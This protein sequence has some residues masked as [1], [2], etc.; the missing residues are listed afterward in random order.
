MKFEETCLFNELTDGQRHALETGSFRFIN[1]TAGS[2]KTKTL[3]ALVLKMLL[4][5]PALGLSR[6]CLFTYTRKAAGEI[7]SRL[8]AEVERILS[9]PKGATNASFK[10]RWEKI[11]EEIPESF[12]GTID[13]IIQKITNQLI[14]NGQLHD[15]SPGYR[16]I[17]V[18]SPSLKFVEAEI[19][20]RMLLSTDPVI[21]DALDNL[22]SATQQ[23]NFFDN[24][25]DLFDK[26]NFGESGK[27][28]IDRI[29]GN[30][31]P[32]DRIFEICKS[33]NDTKI[34]SAWL[35]LQ[36][37]FEII[38]KRATQA[39]A[40]YENFQAIAK[41]FDDNHAAK[42]ENLE[43]LSGIL[44]RG[45]FDEESNPSGFEINELLGAVLET[46]FI[47]T[48]KLEKLTRP[49][50]SGETRGVKADRS[51]GTPAVKSEKI[52]ISPSL[53]GQEGSE[54]ESENLQD[55]LVPIVAGLKDVII[56]PS[57]IKI[58]EI[59]LRHWAYHG[60]ILEKIF[61][62][63]GDI[64]REFSTYTFA[65]I[66]KIL[67]DYFKHA[68]FKHVP[69]LP[70]ARV[71]VDEF[72]DNTEKQW[73]LA[74]LLSGG[75]HKDA[76]TWDNLTIVGDPEQSIYF[77]RN[78][79]PMLMERVKRQWMDSNPA[80]KATWYDSHIEKNNSGGASSNAREKI[81]ISVLDLN[82]R[83]PASILRLIDHASRTTLGAD[84]QAFH[85][86]DE[87]SMSNPKNTDLR[88]KTEVVYLKPMTDLTKS[89]TGDESR[90]LQVQTLAR[91]LQR[92]HEKGFA[93][94]DMV[95]L[96]HSFGDISKQLKNALHAHGIPFKVLYKSSIWEYQEIIDLVQLARAVS[97]DDAETAL[98]ATLR[99]PIGRLDDG[100]ILFL[101]SLGKQ[102]IR[103][104][105]SLFPYFLN[106]PEKQ[107]SWVKTSLE[108]LPAGMLTELRKIAIGLE[109][110]K[111]EQI[112]RLAGFLGTQGSWR[113]AVDRCP[114]H[115]LIKKMVDESDA[116]AAIASMIPIRTP[117]ENME[118]AAQR[119]NDFFELVSIFDDELKLPL[120]RLARHLEERASRQIS[121]S[122]YMELGPDEDCVALMT[123]HGAK[124]LEAPVVALIEF[125]EKT[126]KEPSE[127]ILNPCFFKLDVPV[128]LLEEALNLP[129]LR[130]PEEQVAI[131]P[132]F[133]ETKD[134]FSKF[135]SAVGRINK[136]IMERESLRVLHVAMTR[137]SS[138]LIFAD[139]PDA[140]DPSESKPSRFNKVVEA[141]SL[142]PFLVGEKYEHE[143]RLEGT[144][145]GVVNVI[146]DNSSHVY[147]PSVATV[148]AI[149]CHDHM[150][151]EHVW[152]IPV[153][154]LINALEID[155]QK[156]EQVVSFL[157]RGISMYAGGLTSILEPDGTVSNLVNMG[158]II[159]SIIHRVFE[160]GD[161]LPKSEKDLCP[162]L[163]SMA[164]SYLNTRED[165]ESGKPGSN[166]TAKI[167]ARQVMI[168][169][170]KLGQPEFKKL[171]SLAEETEGAVNEKD[172]S[173][174][175]GNCIV[176][177]RFDRVYPYKNPPLIVDW[178]T[179]NDSM[180]KITKR[181]E[182]QMK[183][184]ALGLYLQYPN[185]KRP[186]K[187]CV[188]LGLTSSGYM[189]DLTYTSENLRSYFNEINK[190][191]NQSN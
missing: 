46:G 172:F 102:N 97:D 183:L 1:A 64:Y 18:N 79:D 26:Y 186:E 190:L 166:N 12:I 110:Y 56:S 50:F 80:P 113:K 70:F 43:K 140:K 2:G 37:N 29:V 83:T 122:V 49:G 168:I 132:G 39:V 158:A 114:N 6:I 66:Q 117:G 30:E 59:T 108:S 128:S 33:L 57:D 78:S 135:K 72:Q 16:C 48:K 95:V 67:L 131:T 137:P 8:S 85:S 65:A 145:I 133:T 134:G 4:D 69:E 187:I 189:I 191:L 24:A 101:A 21:K 88:K 45:I 41:K 76:S 141:W 150:K 100:D 14:A 154:K 155:S 9:S 163:E 52:I 109:N 17:D 179:D 124:G 47:I 96:A 111:K 61:A 161:T 35:S 139:Y 25:L 34:Q 92:Q 71:L 15:V 152:S 28:A 184:Y 38:K 121:E 22:T 103:R 143:V 112:I 31:N 129:L 7:K 188:K 176:Y 115:L 170:S 153:T 146:R 119:I 106:E 156:Q 19:K 175:I 62:T 20:K 125:T 118:F 77:F 27:A 157:R 10:S 174:R 89:L 55:L 173:M 58:G 107:D 171:K 99:G 144:K 68:G 160:L 94:K 36:S 142:A 86:P 90:Q 82:W 149:S 178:K 148:P 167:I 162:I 180:E 130:L 138:V 182:S 120:S 84:H 60:V 40:D 44:A 63:A 51:R 54:F 3:V 11:R 32:S 181:Y 73:E 127:M 159:G 5:D 53:H 126:E 177:G 165:D 123:A 185:E 98:F 147:K 151:E 116:W 75:D 93:W 81:G 105:L 169:M 136:Q 42:L 87:K 91:E 74:C 164:G 13:A 23:D 104:G